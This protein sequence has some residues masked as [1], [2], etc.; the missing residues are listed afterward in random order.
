MRLLLAPYLI[1]S[2]LS[3]FVP[4]RCVADGHLLIVKAPEAFRP[5]EAIFLVRENEKTELIAQRAVLLEVGED[6]ELLAVALIKPE[7]LLRS[8]ECSVLFKEGDANFSFHSVPSKDC[9][10]DSFAEG[11]IGELNKRI[12]QSEEELRVLRQSIDE[13]QEQIRRLRS[14][15]EVIGNLGRI[16][17][18]AEQIKVLEEQKTRITQDIERLSTFLKQAAVQ[19]S[20]RNFTRRQLELTTQLEELA[21]VVQ[22]VEQDESARRSFSEAQLQRQLAMIEETR[23]ARVPELEAALQSLNSAV[24]RLERRLGFDQ[25][26]AVEDY[27]S[28]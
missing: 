6:K 24:S 7:V 3:L 26:E 17:E 19:T 9:N 18:K 23:S 16:T 11:G 2:V 10:S 27:L 15:A 13:D 28:W 20:P 21:E 14:D 12:S 5:S 22:S 4:I 1:F 25:G 8:A